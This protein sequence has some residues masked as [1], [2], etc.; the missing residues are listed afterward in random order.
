MNFYQLMQLNTSALK[1]MIK[2]EENKKLKQKYI[3]ALVAKAIL[4]L[5]FC[6]VTV[7]LFIKI[8]GSE[9][10]S[11]GVVIVLGLL[12]Y[13]LSNLD[14][15]VKQ[16]SFTIFSIFCIFMVGPHL[17]SI[18]SPIVGFFINFICIMIIVIL[19]CHNVLL[20]NQSIL[21]LSYILLYGNSVSDVNTY[22]NRVLALFVGGILVSVIFYIRQ[23][24]IKFNN[25]FSDIIKG[26]S[27]SNER[28]KWQLKFTIG[29]CLI[30]LITE[31]LNLPRNIWAG[32]ACMSI[33]H[34]NN[35]NVDLRFKIRF[36]YV[37]MGCIIY[38]AI[39][40]LVPVQYSSL[41]GMLGGLLV[42]FCGTYQWQ[43]VFNCFG[44][45]SSAVPIF[46]LEG[47]VI[48]RILNNGFGAIYSKFF[49]TLFDSI[50]EKVVYK[51]KVERATN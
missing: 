15:D 47:A 1:P 2:M 33:L 38:F 20:C 6:I 46:G 9:N 11:A 42:G 22:I 27:F 13:R 12:T 24:H 31:I 48:L 51:D 35:K 37:I 49:N 29:V 36:P 23:R 39:Y 50:Y 32:F 19:S 41:I 25:S 43:T 10:S 8:F 34:P 4:C 21:V 30:L 44:A 7:T 45:L 5:L 16:S 18:S 26:V 40:I 14:F 17:A 3:T 28:T